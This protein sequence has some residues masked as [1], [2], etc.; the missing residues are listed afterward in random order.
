[1]D[2]SPRGSSG[3]GILQARILEWVTISYSR[4]LPGSGTELT[5][6]TSPAWAGRFFTTSATW[7]APCQSRWSSVPPIALRN[8]VFLGTQAGGLILVLVQV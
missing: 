8:W 4:D 1:M 5:P 6:L 2:C 3:H 7:K